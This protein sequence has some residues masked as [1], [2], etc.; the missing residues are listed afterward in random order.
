MV[1]PLRR[2]AVV[3]R[4]VPALVAAAVVAAVSVSLVRV[5]EGNDRPAAL[6]PALAFATEGPVI[7]VRVLDPEADAARYNAELKAQ[8]L[9]VTLR[10]SPVSPSVVGEAIAASIEP[11]PREDEIGF[12]KYP[13]GCQGTAC[14]PEFSI[15]VGYSGKADLYIGR[16]AKP[17]EGY[18]GAGEADGPGEALEGVE[19]ENQTV[20]YVLRKLGERG[21]TAEY[22]VGEQSEAKDT[23]PDNWRVED[24]ALLSAKRAVLFVK[25]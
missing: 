24:V 7:K 12:G 16:A 15:P 17:G 8:G 21:M 20:A 25:P 13:A 6:G 2:R 1:V 9:N 14:S 23:V 10:L 5:P 18:S 19:F 3:R 22:R 4:L 11:G